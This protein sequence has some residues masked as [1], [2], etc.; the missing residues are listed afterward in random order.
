[1]TP[2]KKRILALLETT[3]LCPRTAS[4]KAFTSPRNASALL[5]EIYAEG[6]SH[7]TGWDRPA[8]GA[9]TPIYS[10]GPGEDVP[11]PAP[12]PRVSVRKTKVRLE[13]RLLAAVAEAPLTAEQAADRLCVIPDHIR[14]LFKRLHEQKKVRIASWER[15][16]RGPYFPSY[17]AGTGRDKKKPDPLPASARCMAYRKRLKGVFDERY[18]AVREMQK[19]NIPGR[20]LVIDGKVVYQQ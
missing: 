2:T 1:M 9:C 14:K 16:T 18:G 7:I 5:A 4:E 11:R 15:K 3:P 17:L 12:K 13:D 8:R 20:R 10:L 19:T 6:L